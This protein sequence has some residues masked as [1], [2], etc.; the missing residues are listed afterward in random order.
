LG[1]LI[2]AL[3]AADA[4]VAIDLDDFDPHPVGHLAQLA[5]LVG[6]RLIDRADPQIEN[7]AAHRSRGETLFRRRGR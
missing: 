2:P 3:G 7:G 6:C 5:L 4:V 1:P